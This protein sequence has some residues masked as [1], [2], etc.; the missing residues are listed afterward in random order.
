MVLTL[1]TS[2]LREERRVFDLQYHV[3]GFSTFVTPNEDLL[4]IIQDTISLFCALIH[5]LDKIK[6][7]YHMSR[8][9]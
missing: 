7:R 3:Q 9:S 1:A 2:G 4:V 8:V 5:P 6:H